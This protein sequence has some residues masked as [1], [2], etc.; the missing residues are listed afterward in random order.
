MG[1][2]IHLWGVERAE[3]IHYT[4]ITARHIMGWEADS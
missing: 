2:D 4:G 3:S 1:G